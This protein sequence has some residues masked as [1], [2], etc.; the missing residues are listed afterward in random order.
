MEGQIMAVFEMES[1]YVKEGMGEKHDEAM[2]GWLKFVNDHRELFR[3]WKSVRYFVKTVA[4]TESD[5]HFIIW[6][7]DS[8]AAFEAYKE[9]RKDYTGPYAEYKKV[10]PY[11][12]GV[13]DHNNMSIEFWK[14]L[15]RDLWIE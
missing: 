5:R 9:R 1:W 14:D 3:E 10:D 6:E 4:G 8:M 2:R 15:D 12:M 11:Y 7:Y 13:F